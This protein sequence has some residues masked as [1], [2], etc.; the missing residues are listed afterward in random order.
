MTKLWAKAANTTR[1]PTISIAP[2]LAPEA[3]TSAAPPSSRAR[4]MPKLP[5]NILPKRRST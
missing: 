1:V 5:R 2:K 4:L 3:R